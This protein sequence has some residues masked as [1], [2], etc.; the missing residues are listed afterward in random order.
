MHIRAAAQGADVPPRVLVPATD[1]AAVLSR[2]ASG[3]LGDGAG[4]GDIALAPHAQGIVAGF[5]FAR[6]VHNCHRH[7]IAI[8]G[9]PA[10][11]A[12]ILTRTDS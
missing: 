5:A 10:S 4:A 2:D 8:G 1:G 7:H 9:R 11:R 6:W 3:I 12:H